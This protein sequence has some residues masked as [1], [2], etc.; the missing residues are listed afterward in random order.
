MKSD[1]CGG[2]GDP[3]GCQGEPR[4]CG[5]CRSEEQEGFLC[6]CCMCEE[7]PPEWRVGGTTRAK[8]RVVED[9]VDPHLC[10]GLRAIQWSE[11]LH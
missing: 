1:K 8:L 11:P 3:S 10:K 2:H 7:M 9:V 5:D 6:E 4:G